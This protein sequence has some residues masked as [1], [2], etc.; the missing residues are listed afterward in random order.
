MQLLRLIS[1]LCILFPLLSCQSSAVPADTIYSSNKGSQI[2]ATSHATFDQPW[3]MTFLPNGEL[4]VTEKEGRLLRV[5]LDDGRKV[6]ITGI[7]K[8]AY[9]GQGGLGDIIIHPNYQ[10]NN[11]VYLSYVEMDSSGN[12]GAVVIRAKLKSSTESPKLENIETI[13]RQT[14]K[15]TG[16]GHYSHKMAFS[17]DG[18]LFITSGDRQKQEPAQ[19]WEQN[20]GKIIRLNADGTVPADNP[21][22]DKG[23]LAKSFWSVGHRNMLG[24]TFDKQGLLWSHEMGPKDG[25]EFN[26]IVG[27]DN[28]GWPIVSEGVQ[29]SGVNIPNHDTRPEFHAPEVS[30]VPTVAPSGLIIYYGSSFPNWQGNAFIGGLRSESLLRLKIKGTQSEEAERFDMNKRIRE[31]EQGAK[32]AI[33]VLEDGEDA[34]LLRLTPSK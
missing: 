26:N 5:N 24:I 28:Y 18:Y 1:Y 8:V 12:K 16:S 20:L 9:G 11:W 23:E 15:V 21:F 30:W 10:D 27:G 3:A 4:L 34:R 19:S 29:Y 6:T 33:W 14:P 22:Q 2:L 7:P 32:G 13:W 31:V 17:P 25:D